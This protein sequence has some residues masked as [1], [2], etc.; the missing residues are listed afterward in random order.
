M[1]RISS[2]TI[3]RNHQSLRP[4]ITIKSVGFVL[5]VPN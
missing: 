1:T 2:R 5:E 3:A 4:A